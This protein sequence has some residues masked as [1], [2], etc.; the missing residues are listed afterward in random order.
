MTK[1]ALVEDDEAVS[2][3]YQMKLHKEGY[4]VVLARDGAEGV[5][6][7]QSTQPDLVLLDLMLPQLSGDRVLA[8][9]RQQPWGQNIKVIIMTNLTED[10]AP[11]ELHELG[12]S[13]FIVKAQYTPTQLMEVIKQVLAE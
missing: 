4:E 8:A 3:L 12:V 2:Q 9:I 5:Q 7:V 1:I 13:R 11:K 10:E 6:V